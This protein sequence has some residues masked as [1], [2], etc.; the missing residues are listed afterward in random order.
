MA[1]G[2]LKYGMN[3]GRSSL[4]LG[5][6]NWRRGAATENEN[7]NGLK[8]GRRGFASWQSLRGRLRVGTKDR[9]GSKRNLSALLDCPEIEALVLP[10]RR[11]FQSR[12]RSLGAMAD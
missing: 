11:R 5:V 8:M 3:C 6:G 7:L 12:A 2:S 4:R 1:A 10:S 9:A